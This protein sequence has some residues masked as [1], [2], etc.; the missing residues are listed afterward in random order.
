M[1]R[2]RDALTPAEI[3]QEL[4][5]ALFGRGCVAWIGSGLSR[6]IYGDWLQTVDQLCNRCGVRPFDVSIA[7]PD[8][9]QL[10][11]KAEECK[12]A[13]LVVYEATLA[14]LYGKTDVVT[15]KAYSMLMKAPFKAYATTNH[16]PLLSEAGETEGFRN[17]HS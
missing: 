9:A 14:N 10:I 5:G 6:P 2:T 12:V 1:V 4:L 11:D 3:A 8:A 7:N 16:D 17:V 13:N 15:R